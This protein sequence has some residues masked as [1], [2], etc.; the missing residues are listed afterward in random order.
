MAKCSCLKDIP[1][2]TFAHAPGCLIGLQELVDNMKITNKAL[3]D[4]L[5]YNK[6]ELARERDYLLGLLRDLE[7]E[8]YELKKE[9]GL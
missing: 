8:E 6:K 4:S 9:L 5:P 2:A 1:D 3:K 7:A